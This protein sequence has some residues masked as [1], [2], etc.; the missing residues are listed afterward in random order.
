M[1]HGLVAE[2]STGFTGGPHEQSLLAD[3]RFL[4]HAV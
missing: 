1:L 3:S 4:E 2:D